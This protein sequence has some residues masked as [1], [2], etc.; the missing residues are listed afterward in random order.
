[1]RVPKRSVQLRV[2][3]GKPASLTMLK[4]KKARGKSP[5]GITKKQKKTKKI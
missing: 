4:L 1:M 5:G 3:K 2:K